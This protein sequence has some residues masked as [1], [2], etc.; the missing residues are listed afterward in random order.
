[1]RV[2]KEEIWT[3]DKLHD[4][5][6]AKLGENSLFIVSNREPF[7]HVQEEQ[8]GSTI[9]IRPASGVV[10]ALDPI[11]RACGGTWIAHGSGNVDKKYVNSKDKLGVPPE[12]NRY[13]LKRVWLTK[14]EEQGYYYGFSNEGLWPL[15]M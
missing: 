10:T 7:M 14:E 1:V 6:Q 5:V 3:K 11:L 4:L 15:S 8:T 12:D 2:Q 9:C 13:I